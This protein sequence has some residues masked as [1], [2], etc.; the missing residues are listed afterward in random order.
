[1]KTIIPC[2]N[3]IAI[4]NKMKPPKIAASI[5]CASFVDLGK[6]VELL[7]RSNC[8]M[9]HFDVMDGSF[10]PR[11]GLHPEILSSIRK[12]TNCE[13]DVHLMVN[14]PEA[15]CDTF[16]DAGADYIVVHQE[17]C[18]HLHRTLSKI[19]SLGKKAGVALNPATSIKTIEEV[20][21]MVDLVT[22]MAINPGIVGHKLIPSSIDK[23]RKA[24]R[25]LESK[26]SHALI[27]IDGGVT[28]DSAIDMVNSGADVLVCGS[29]TIY[30]PNMT[31]EIQ[32]R[33]LREL[34]LKF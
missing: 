2:G 17:A 21:D 8:E 9:I 26:G 32:I 24:K 6:E 12:I 19:K 7:N 4:L 34:F 20:L 30:R 13:I 33:S 10:V 16:S 25:W 5:I 18:S 27:Q 14:N 22:I 3:G 23:I 1:V 29:S 31:S 11:F 15:Y 28:F